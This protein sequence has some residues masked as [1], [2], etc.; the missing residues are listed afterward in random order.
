MFDVENEQLEALL[1]EAVRFD[2]ENIKHCYQHVNTE[3]INSEM[4]PTQCLV[5]LIIETRN[6]NKILAKKGD[7]HNQ[8]NR[9]QCL[10]NQFSMSLICVDL[11]TTLNESW[12]AIKARFHWDYK[13]ALWYNDSMLLFFFFDSYFVFFFAPF[14]LSIRF[15]LSC[16]FSVCENQI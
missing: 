11:W 9:K 15:K 16:F 3:L 6:E 8:E 5:H 12:A 4:N 13:S 2:K 7:S 1:K 14:F 10:H